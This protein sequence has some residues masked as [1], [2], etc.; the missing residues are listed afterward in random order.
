VV[1]LVGAEELADE[2]VEV[3]VL[4]VFLVLVVFGEVVRFEVVGHRR[5]R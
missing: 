1:E 3:D 5:A 2:F 4:V